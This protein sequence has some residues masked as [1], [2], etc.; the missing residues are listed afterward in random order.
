MTQKQ[1]LANIRRVV[2]IIRTRLKTDQTD[3]DRLATRLEIRNL[4]NYIYRE[5]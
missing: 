1:E 3:L 2:R 5:V 4:V